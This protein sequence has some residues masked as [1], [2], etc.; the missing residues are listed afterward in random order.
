MY[1]THEECDFFFWKE[2]VFLFL[3]RNECSVLVKNAVLYMCSIRNDFSVSGW[4]MCSKVR[5]VCS[6]AEK[7]T[8]SRSEI[9]VL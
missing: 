4:N 6:L 5:K 1:I 2:H 3:I 9:C 7:N 8:C